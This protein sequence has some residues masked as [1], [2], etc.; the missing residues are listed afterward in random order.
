MTSRIQ[1]V[2]IVRTHFERLIRVRES[3]GCLAR[4]E[5]NP[6]S[7]IVNLCIVRVD[8]DSA[9]EIDNR[10]IVIAFFRVGARACRK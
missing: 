6:G 3:L 1:G 8:T 2:R 10:V 9:G 4:F 7:I 5:V